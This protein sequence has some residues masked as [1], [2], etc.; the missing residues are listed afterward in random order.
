ME[1]KFALI[2]I[3]GGATKVSGWII[4]LDE[5]HI[6]F[7]LSDINYQAKYSDFEEYNPQ[8]KPVNIQTQLKEMGETINLT[9]EEI[10]QGATY[11]KAC[12]T[13]IERL[14]ELN[15]D[16]PVLVGIGMPGLK[17]KDKRG[18]SAVANGPRIPEY[19]DKIEQILSKKGIQL[20][21][22]IAHIGSDADYCGIGENYAEG[23]GFQ[24]ILNGYYLGGGTGAADA[25]KLNGNLVPL[26]N[27]K[28]WLAKTWEM[29]NDLEISMEKYASASGI[30]FIY[31]TKCGSSVEELNQNNIYPPQIAEKALSGDTSAIETFKE[32]SKYLALLFYERITSLNCGTQNL[33]SFVNPNRDKLSETHE[34]REKTFERIVVG[35]RLSDLMGSKVG[36]EVLT[37]PLVRSLS[38]LIDQ[39]D[40]LSDNVKSYY[41]HDSKIKNERL[42][43]SGLREAPAIGAGIDAY[44]NYVNK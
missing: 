1:K 24:N 25:L 7:N 34:F 44:L 43:L 23:G 5:E 33:F 31:S 21:L 26:D 35:Q 4:D 20:L 10:Q 36:N 19:C 2:G 16:I 39:S 29:K 22:P 6:Q 17:T 3:D 18:L 9:D 13:A 42:F 37:K 41:L 28:P 40:F 14:A 32:I 30:Q 11:I 38:D 8:F 27:T 15:K 12:A